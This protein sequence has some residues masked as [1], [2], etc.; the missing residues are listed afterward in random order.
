ML[1]KLISVHKLT[2]HFMKLKCL[3][4][5]IFLLLF[6][7]SSCS[8]NDGFISTD[9]A[10]T[11]SAKAEYDNSNFGIYKGVFVGSSGIIYIDINNDNTVSATLIIDGQR[12]NFATSDAVQQNEATIL[13][14]SDGSDSFT[15]SVL[16]NGATPA[17]TYLF[18]NGHPN[19]AILIVKETS[20]ALVK[21]Y[22]GSYTGSDAG[23]F[24]A[25]IY[26]NAFK[27]LAKKS[28]NTT[29]TVEGSVTDNQI[30]ATGT[31]SGGNVFTGT[32]AGN[33]LSGNWINPLAN[34]SGTWSGIRTY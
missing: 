2:S 23:I 24:N 25:V 7:F 34:L 27:G 20:S 31:V 8:K 4:N 17:I 11:P 1:F 33:N 28:D 19:S 14:F 13:N 5:L 12:I 10:D 9:L 6:V 16:A 32:L 26:N 18:I 22:E 21:C 15:F 3:S 29:F 30:T